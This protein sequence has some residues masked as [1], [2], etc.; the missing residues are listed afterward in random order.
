[1]ITENHRLMKVIGKIKLKKKVL[2]IAEHLL[3]HLKTLDEG[4]QTF[5]NSE[6][7]TGVVKKKTSS[8]TFFQKQVMKKNFRKSLNTLKKWTP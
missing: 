8:Q 5:K 4:Y 6:E 1:M 2:N 3:K 7:R